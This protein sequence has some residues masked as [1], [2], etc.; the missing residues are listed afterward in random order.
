MGGYVD[1]VE[2]E[3]I[4]RVLMFTD[5]EGS[6]ARWENDTES[7][8]ALMRHHDSLID[9]V[10]QRHNGVLGARTGDGAIVLFEQV[11]DAA[12]CAMEFQQKLSRGPAET[13]VQATPLMV[14]IGIHRGV[15]EPRG[16][17]HY[18]PA[19]HRAA[20]VM[21]AGH[22]GQ[23][24]VSA[25]VSHELLQHS[26]PLYYVVARGV[27]QLKGFHEPEQLSEIVAAGSTPDN[28]GVRSAVTL[29]N[30]PAIDPTTLIGRDDDLHRLQPLLVPGALVTL[31]GTGGVGK[32]RLA[33]EIA[34]LIRPRFPDGAWFIDL[35]AVT[36]ADRV[37]S[38]LAEGLGIVDDS[39]TPLAEG[40]IH[41]IRTRRMLVLLDNCEHVIDAVSAFLRSLRVAHHEATLLCTSQRDVAVTGEMVEIVSPLDF[42]GD[43][44]TSPAG[45]LLLS[46]VRRL[47]TDASFSAADRQAVASI[48]ERLD[49]IPLAIEL[50]AGRARVMT[51]PEIADG[52]SS[53]FDLLAS[54]QG[55]DRHRT[56]AAAIDW[57][58]ELLTADERDVLLDVSV[59]SGVFTWRAAAT[60]SGRD[61][62]DIVNI[63]DELVRRSVLVRAQSG[64]RMLVPLCLRCADLL[65]KSGRA[66]EVRGRHAAWFSSS[67]PVP[68]DVLDAA[69]VAQR[70]DHV[71]ATYEDLHTAHAW[72]VE[73]DVAAAAR[74]ALGLC[75]AFITRSR[76]V[77][78][79]SLLQA[80]DTDGVPTELRIEVLSWISAVCWSAG[81]NEL[82]ESSARRAIQLAADNS[83]P[84]P[85]LAATRL[86]I[87]LVFSDRLDEALDLA[88]SAETALRSGIGS[89]GHLFGPLAV[90]IS[91]GGQSA[92][93]IALSDEGVRE[94]RSLGTLRLLSALAN[95]ILLQP[96][97]Q[98]AVDL[99]HEIVALAGAVGR[100]SARAHAIVA[101][102]HRSK[103]DGDLHGFLAG[104]AQFA[105]LLIADEPTSVVQ[106][107]QWV[108]P[109]TAGPLPRETAV[110]LAALETLAKLHN[111]SGTGQEQDRRTDLQET[112]RAI[113]GHDEYQRA[114][115][116]GSAMTLAGVAD[117]LHWMTDSVNPHPG[118]PDRNS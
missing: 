39:A 38:A 89:P 84:L 56:M 115:L 28:R 91:L 97:T 87:R 25:I 63:L 17:E 73:H 52:L 103:H 85:V 68:F 15:I 74:L 106:I 100:T 33:L 20:R 1:F 54:R 109:A 24:I 108:P 95:R 29:G 16:G 44:A 86:A 37:V 19:M 90:V 10:V 67:V 48:C 36:A 60:V 3:F 9:E 7:M 55:P 66:H 114:S 35:A 49:G 12:H 98:L 53:R 57:S 14:R 30:L 41:A 105:D 23:V 116:E 11:T 71:L 69:V 111:H 81:R 22:G 94:A 118:N 4:D 45:Q 27:H 34:S 18:G 92:R 42:N 110:M 79:I 32:T 107:M 93:A 46:H 112:L 2:T 51:L 96:G 64:L 117:L 47:V 72:L 102:A 75:D 78:A 104:I 88:E 62:I 5:I 21:A 77:E 6:T 59:F 80:C 40:V 65:N 31:V 101:I 8:R 61:D 13:G 70:I 113:V 26:T 82:G 99:S 43:A 50:A 76:N 58:I 83:L